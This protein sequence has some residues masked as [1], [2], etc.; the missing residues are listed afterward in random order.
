MEDFEML[1]VEKTPV[2]KGK[3][4]F[5][6]RYAECL[7]DN[8]YITDPSIAR[9]QEIRDLIV[10]LI[11][12]DKS[13]ILVG[14]PGIGKTAIVEGL[15][16]RI[17]KN[18]VPGRLQNH[19]VYKINSSSLVGTIVLDGVEELKIQVMINDLMK[20]DKTILF[21]D[22]IHTLIG[23]KEST[24]MDLANILKPAVDRG[25]IKLI[26]ATTTAEYERYLVKDRAFIRRFDKVMV[27]EP[28]R[29]Q[30]I[31]I[32]IKTLP[33]IEKKYGIKIKYTIY[34]IRLIMEFITDATSE[35]KREYILSSRYPDIVL[36][37]LS[38]AFAI[39]AYSDKSDV[40]L[41]DI[42]EAFTQ[43]KAIYPDVIKKEIVV[44]KEK[45]KDILKEENI[46]L[47]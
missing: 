41:I 40:D 18:E 6:D 25:A 11:T 3:I 12:P 7:T 29:D 26:G 20:R 24:S 9:E 28:T 46:T 16:Y 21:I 33:K 17:K 2:I 31:E 8:E 35:Y 10:I 36:T 42:Y 44:F 22:E 37:I 30:T 43:S 38:K 47:E 13:G 23:N 27:A 14:L 19:K 45:F 34:V 5:I 15:A 4:S 1:E 32:L 39:A